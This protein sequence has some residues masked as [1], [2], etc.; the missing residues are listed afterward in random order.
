MKKLNPHATRRPVDG[1]DFEEDGVKFVGKTVE[2]LVGHLTTY[3][4]S[5]RKQLGDPQAD[6]I[7][8]IAE[9]W[10]DLVVDD[11]EEAE[12][13]ASISDGIQWLYG[14]FTGR[15]D[16]WVTPITQARSEIC[17]SC[18]HNIERPDL[19]G[20]EQYD[21]VARLK[22]RN[23]LNEFQLGW[24]KLH[25]HDNRIAVFLKEV[26]TTRRQPKVCWCE[27]TTT[28]TEKTRNSTS[29]SGS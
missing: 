14:L 27:P 17:K 21:Y 19:F 6:I 15:E 8:H 4:T 10:P 13:P 2:E 25:G 12:L 9:K 22:S 28:S 3:R 29:E 5:V 16:F 18:K 24:C 26:R 23:R 7:A 20:N 1:F 11:G